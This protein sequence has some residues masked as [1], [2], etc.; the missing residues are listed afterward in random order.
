MSERAML[1]AGC[2]WGVEDKLR[3]VKGVMD[4]QVGYTGGHVEHPEYEE[5][6][7]GTTGHAEA[8][9][10]DF[11]PEVVSYAELLEEFWDM[12]DPT[13]LNRQGPDEGEQY[14]SAIF[15]YDEEQ[16]RTAEAS[17]ADRQTL[18][19]EAIVT[20]ITQAGEFWRA[21]E[22]HQRYLEKKRKLGLG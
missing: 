3:Q 21:E 5:V 16:K 7:K 4:V 6:C 9:L 1:A 2:F 11:N 17:R 22:Y 19:D 10:I 20:E 15:Y 13:T 14:R 12:H 18:F 8:V